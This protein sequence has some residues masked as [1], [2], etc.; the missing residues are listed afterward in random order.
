[1][2]ALDCGHAHELGMMKT[3]TTEITQWLTSFTDK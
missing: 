3:S 2:P 1:M